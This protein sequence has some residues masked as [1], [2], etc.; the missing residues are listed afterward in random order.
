MHRDTIMLDDQGESALTRILAHIH[1]RTGLVFSEGDRARA[2]RVIAE[3]VQSKG[4]P[5]IQPYEEVL[6]ADGPELTELVR[7]LTIKETSFFR[8]VQQFAAF[9]EYALPELLAT[10]GAACE[11]NLWSAG[12][13]TG[14]EPYSLA[15][16]LRDVLGPALLHWRVRLWATDIDMEALAVARR[17]VYSAHQLRGLP[18]DLRQRYTIAQGSDFRLSDELREMVTFEA[19]NLNAPEAWGRVTRMDVIFCRNVIIYFNLETNR[20]LMERFH[21][22]LADD[23]YLFLGH[24]ETLWEIS[25]HFTPLHTHDTFIYQP[26]RHAAPNAEKA[27]KGRVRQRHAGAPEARTTGRKAPAHRPIPG[28]RAKRP[29]QA[30]PAPATPHVEPGALD[31]RLSATLTAV[32]EAVN[33]GQNEY[34][35][36]LLQPYL[37]D[38]CAEAHL[39]AGRAL[40]NRGA[41]NEA[42]HQCDR[43]V[44]ADPLCSEAYYLGGLLALNANNLA[45][46]CL[47]FE[48]LVYLCPEQP[49][50]H[51]YLGVVHQRQHH[52]ERAALSYRNALQ[53]VAQHTNNEMLGE[54]SV[55]MLRL[56]C[57]Q[58]IGGKEEKGKREKG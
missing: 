32:R 30:P 15:M 39:L 21:H 3:C 1:A 56:A 14:A 58:G 19:L 50:A 5:A 37:G 52:A 40:A 4:L 35:L 57:Q 6:Q 9:R 20:A 54:M 22:T 2:R 53:L 24:S 43:A 48:R 7:R 8:H 25:D 46:A 33:Q 28:I 38:H 34:A 42:A 45:G 55:G 18:D 49:L 29:A 51:Y 26:K 17:A 41:M 31:V 23:G 44:Q 11:L 36:E 16:V 47:A 10:R 13:S 27:R 12:C